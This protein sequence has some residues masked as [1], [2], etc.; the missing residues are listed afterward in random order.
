M[1]RRRGSALVAGAAL[2]GAAGLALLGGCGGGGSANSADGSGAGLSAPQLA[3]GQ[4]AKQSAGDVA[5]AP[6]V[7][8]APVVSTRALIRTA[9][10]TV[11]VDDVARQAQA[12]A[13]IAA[14]A[15]GEVFSD[16]RNSGDKT[17]QRTADL[18]LKVPPGQLG[19]VLDNLAKLGTEEARHTTTDDVT[20]QVAD[21][22]SRVRSAKASLT[23][24]RSL[25]DR[26][27]TISEV[28]ALESQISQREADLESLQARQRA[29][30][31]QTATA[32]ITVHLHG[33]A[34][35][36]A[37]TRSGNHPTG[38]WSALKAGWHAF[39]V[40]LSW[41]VTVLG[42]VLPF[43]VLALVLAYGAWW[44]SRRNRAAATV[45]PA[46]PPSD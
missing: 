4:G 25:Y 12:A 31:T 22:D 35:G 34:V 17:D 40:S 7:R 11:A 1:N 6:P 37:A 9:E 13:Q 16:Q 8:G 39:A 32:T 14:N 10:L 45:A 36:P 19:P 26:A 41:L 29:L 18:V 21:V 23:R 27:G 42:A 15:D 5:S 43:A 30:A 44:F 46:V 28:A 33:R 2:L 3:E 38:F 24:L 20:E